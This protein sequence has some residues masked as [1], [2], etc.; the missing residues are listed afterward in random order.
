ML[1]YV[2]YRR[3]T[4]PT[5]PSWS[6]HTTPSPPEQTSNISR[7][8]N[9]NRPCHLYYFISLGWL[10]VELLPSNLATNNGCEDLFRKG[11]T[12]HMSLGMLDGCKT[13]NMI[14]SNDMNICTYRLYDICLTSYFIATLRSNWLFNAGSSKESQQNPKKE[15]K[16]CISETK[17]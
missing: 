9:K 1:V 13:K 2:V 6:L 5:H 17:L 11:Y 3:V 14:Q 16:T 15:K 4:P 10:P 7:L 12:I 8:H